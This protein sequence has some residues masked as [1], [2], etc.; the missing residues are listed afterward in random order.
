ME[1]PYNQGGDTQTHDTF[2]DLGPGG[3]NVGALHLGCTNCLE[4]PDDSFFCTRLPF[5]DFFRARDVARVYLLSSALYLD[6]S[7]FYL[8]ANNVSGK[9]SLMPMHMWRLFWVNIC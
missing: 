2:P 9:H 3:A 5:G 4:L 1:I 7:I 8:C 6:V